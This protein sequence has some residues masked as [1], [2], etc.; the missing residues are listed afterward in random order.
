MKIP[1][2]LILLSGFCLLSSGCTDTGD[3]MMP[4]HDAAAVQAG[5]KT[6]QPSD[7]YTLRP[8]DL[9]RVSLYQE[10]D[11]NADAQ[12][13]QD[14]DVI[15]PLIGKVHVAGKTLTETQV[16]ITEKLK[17]FFKEPSLTLLILKYAERKVYIDGMVGRAGP[18]LFPPEEKLTLSKAISIAGGILPRGERSD[19][20]LT[21]MI[22]GKE[23]TITVDMSEIN[24]GRSPDIELQENDR[25][26]V[27]DSRI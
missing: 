2:P 10:P 8:T 16:L 25:I 23:K 14:G 17:R 3:T 13:D 24:A 7:N 21:R 19:V 5:P 18:V 20:K 9:L 22:D 27:R 11:F 26:Y 6:G 15:L 4:T 1:L 12:V